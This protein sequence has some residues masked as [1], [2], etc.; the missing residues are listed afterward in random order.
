MRSTST[1]QTGR[2][3]FTLLEV[4]LV[5]AILALLAAVVAPRLI[6]TQKQAQIDTTRSQISM[7]DDVLDLYCQQ[8]GAYPS[9]DQGLNALMEEPTEDPIPKAW[10]GPYLK[11][12][13]L[14][15]PWGNPYQY[16]FPG[17]RNRDKPDIWSLGPDSEDGSDDDLGNWRNETEEDSS[18]RTPSTDR[19]ERASDRSSRRERSRDRDEM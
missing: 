3:A 17:D 9:T 5:V 4:L 14:V 13:E 6:G 19:G 7:L 10:A 8:N 11:D 12:R 1:A 15:D 2:A 18:D 16:A